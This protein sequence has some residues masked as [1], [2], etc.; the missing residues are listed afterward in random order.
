V[1]WVKKKLAPEEVADAEKRAT[2]W[3]HQHSSNDEA[4]AS[5]K[6]H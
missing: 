5:A 3:Q 4:L 1:E 2:A 6:L